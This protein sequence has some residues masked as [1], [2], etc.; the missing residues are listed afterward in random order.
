[1]EPR[2]HAISRPAL[3]PLSFG[4]IRPRG[5][6]FPFSAPQGAATG[7]RAA[8]HRRGQASPPG[9]PGVPGAGLPGDRCV[10]ERVRRVGRGEAMQQPISRAVLVIITCLRQRTV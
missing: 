9:P 2:L 5:L 1:M 3:M 8:F 6:Q 7:C 10:G 4:E